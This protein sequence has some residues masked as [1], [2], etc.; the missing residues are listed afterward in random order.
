MVVIG[1]GLR[2]APAVWQAS[3][4][5]GID[6]RMQLHPE[7]KRALHLAQQ[8]HEAEARRLIESLAE[9]GERD[10]MFT[11]ADAHWRGILVPRDHERAFQLFR[12]ASDAGQ[13]MAVRAYTNL[14]ANGATGERRWP[15]AL[16]RLESEAP[17]DSR[18]SAMLQLIRAMDVD[19]QGDPVTLPS[20]QILSERPQ[21]WLYPGAFTSEEC[22]FLMAV[23]EPTYEESKVVSVQ[24]NVRTQLRTSDGSTIHWLIEDPATHALNRRLAALAGTA[25]DQGEPL[26]ILRY[27]PGQEYK[28]HLDWLMCDNPRIL[29]ALVYLNEG[30]GGGETAFVKTGLKV[31]GRKGDVLVFR[32]QAPDGGMDPL[33]EHAGLPVTHGTKYL[34]SRWMRAYRYLERN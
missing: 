20:K 27:R 2:Q 14:L 17:G 30:Y 28:P 1:R 6:Q 18:R 8:G 9:A 5:M 4:A 25:V 29:T 19:A 24:G 15:L 21:V 11:L 33:S 32:S 12:K 23:A 22:D 3:T 16:E 34:G 13:P 31:K 10:S 7:L 26:H